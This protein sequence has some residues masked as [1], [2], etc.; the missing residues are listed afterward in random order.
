[1]EKEKEIKLEILKIS[2]ELRKNYSNEQIINTANYFYEFVTSS[3]KENK[4]NIKI[5]EF[6]INSKE[7]QEME[8]NEKLIN[9]LYVLTKIKDL[10]DSIKNNLAGIYNL[11][12]NRSHSEIISFIKEKKLEHVFL[13]SEKENGS[14]KITVI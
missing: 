1:M 3:N 4:I 13:F 9:L 7:H 8:N 10:N 5:D 6:N 14:K 12:I 2:T 11:S